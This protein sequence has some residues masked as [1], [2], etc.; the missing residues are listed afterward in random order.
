M[1]IQQESRNTELKFQL[2]RIL[3]QIRFSVRPLFCFNRLSLLFLPTPPT[4]A[5]LWPSI[6][7]ELKPLINRWEA[8]PQH[9]LPHAMRPSQEI[10][11]PPAPGLVAPAWEGCPRRPMPLPSTPAL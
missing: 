2:P 3:C 1:E 5:A 9:H 6:K 8:P 11:M 10:G 7:V 4:M